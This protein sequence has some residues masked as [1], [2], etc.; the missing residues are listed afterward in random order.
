MVRLIKD[1]PGAEPVD[2]SGTPTGP[3]ATLHA[4]TEFSITITKLRRP[5]DDIETFWCELKV[6]DQL[7]RVRKRTL[8]TAASL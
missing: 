8:E 2:K 5:S 3:P 7:Y 6:G 4:G 1:L